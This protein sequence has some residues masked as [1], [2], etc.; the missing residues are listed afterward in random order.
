MIEDLVAK[1][2]AEHAAEQEHK[3]FCDKELRLSKITRDK[4]TKTLSEL[5]AKIDELTAFIAD[6]G[7][8]IATLQQELRELASAMVAATTARKAEKEKNE[9]TIEDAKE[10][11]KATSN[12]VQV[13]KDFYKRAATA[14]GFL[15]VQQHQEPVVG[16][17]G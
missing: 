12:A 5:A 9:E 3:A 15:Q 2:E 16:S 17:S 6:S 7:E 8:K 13:L 10:A 11:Q 1:L 14:T 4:L